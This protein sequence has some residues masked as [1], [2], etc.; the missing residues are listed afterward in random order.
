MPGPRELFHTNFV[1]SLLLTD[2][3]ISL[4]ASRVGVQ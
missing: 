2:F 4:G 3:E 1:S